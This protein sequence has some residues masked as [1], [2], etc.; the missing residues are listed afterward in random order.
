MSGDQEFTQ[1]DDDATMRALRHSEIRFRTLAAS[2][3]TAIFESDLRGEI[4]YANERWC[5]LL[6]A[7]IPT[8]T[9]LVDRLHPEDLER[10]AALWIDDVASAEPKGFEARCRMVWPRGHWCWYDVS[11]RPMFDD[12]GQIHSY[13]GAVHDV[14][15]LV[16]A[17]Q[18]SQRFQSIVEATSDLVAIVRDDLDIQYVNPAGRDAVGLGPTDDPAQIDPTRHFLEAEWPR[19][20][21]EASR[22]LRDQRIWNGETTFRRA[23]GTDAILSHVIVRGA[24]DDGTNWYASLARDISAV[25]VHRSSLPSDIHRDS[26]TGLLNR[27]AIL[28]ELRTGLGRAVG[29]DRVVGLM[30]IDIDQF[31]LVNDSFGHEAGDELLLELTARLVRSAGSTA[32]LARFGSDEFVVLLEGMTSATAVHRRARHILNELTGRAQLT[33]G[34]VHVSV[35]VGVITDDGTSTA[36]DLLRDADATVSLAKSRGR[37]RLEVFDHRVHS[38]V[39]SRLATEMELRQGLDEQQFVLHYQP[40]IDLK[41]GGMSAVEA[42]VRWEH[43]RYGLLGPDKFLPVV[44]ECGLARQLGS[45][46][47]ETACMAA[48]TWDRSTPGRPRLAV[49]VSADQLNAPD[50]VDEVE[51]VVGRTGI[52]GHGLVLEITEGIVMADAA[53]TSSTLT[54]LRALGAQIAI[55]DF[56]TGYSSLSHLTRL[57]VDVLKVDK[58]FVQALG[59]G[60]NDDEV[61][62]TVVGLGHSLGL[63]V[64]AEGVETEAQLRAVRDLGCEAVQGYYF[65]PAVPASEIAELTADLSWIDHR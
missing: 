62:A 61:T 25:R 42:L 16:E 33:A 53:S 41:R 40:V 1:A 32:R 39:V 6:G 4:L 35:S 17:R 7:G 45:W 36:S 38:Q 29:T 49:N 22:M 56:G 15:E 46:V 58:S 14:T 11:L 3:P 48:S 26:L 57:P 60:A 5:D 28:T 65:S 63:R 51:R 37:G 20:V 24:D 8:D 44:E 34:A 50:F 55:D 2:T 64:V 19:V 30:C 21:D 10:L 31:K 9:T 52:D 47:L 23:D 54:S 12:T 59:S 43:P 18:R 13:L 27:D